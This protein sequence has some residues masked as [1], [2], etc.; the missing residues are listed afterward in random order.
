MD[1]S[2]PGGKQ[3]DAVGA[4]L[5][6]RFYSDIPMNISIILGPIR[7]HFLVHLPHTEIDEW[8]LGQIHW[9][10][11]LQCFIHSPMDVQSKTSHEYSSCPYPVPILWHMPKIEPHRPRRFQSNPLLEWSWPIQVM[12]IVI[13]NVIFRQRETVC[14]SSY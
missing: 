1:G 4:L 8:I 6:D 10:R 11:E 2:T 13:G 12:P 3:H 14:Q 9:P 5:P 7:V